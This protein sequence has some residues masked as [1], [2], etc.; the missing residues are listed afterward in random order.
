MASNDEDE[1]DHRPIEDVAPVG[2]SPAPAPTPGHEDHRWGSPP[3]DGLA[4]TVDERTSSQPPWGL[5][6]ATPVPLVAGR[7]PV[8]VSWAWTPAGD[9]VAPG[10]G[11]G[12]P[13]TPRLAALLVVTCT[14]PGDLIADCIG[15]PALAETAAAGS[16]AYRRMAF[17]DPPREEAVPVADP[18]AL[19]LMSWPP[20]RPRPSLRVTADQPD[21]WAP[22][23]PKP[24]MT[25]GPLRQA[26]TAARAR[27]AADGHLAILVG[28]TDPDLDVLAPHLVQALDESGGGLLSRAFMMIEPETRGRIHDRRRPFKARGSTR[29]RRPRVIGLLLV[30]RLGL[31][32]RHERP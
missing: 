19:V 3:E 23:T 16:R 21:D 7:P 27:A 14:R 20:S 8:L 17:V 4:S 13:L 31:G 26:I 12:P 5:T 25:L 10:S 1:Q 6:R 32:G 28:R 18:A 2:T 15:D 11:V 9:R 24:L 22:V 30:V 29:V